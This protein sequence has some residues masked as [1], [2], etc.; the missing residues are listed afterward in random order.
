MKTKRTVALTLTFLKNFVV[1]NKILI[2][3]MLLTGTGPILKQSWSRTD[4]FLRLYFLLASNGIDTGN[5][6]S[7]GRS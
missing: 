5:C 4:C 6:L 7:K 3:T 2:S 1:F